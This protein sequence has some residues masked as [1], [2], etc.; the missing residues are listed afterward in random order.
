[1]SSTTSTDAP[2]SSSSS[3]GSGGGGQGSFGGVGSYPNGAAY[4]QTVVISLVALALLLM[5]SVVSFRLWACSARELQLMVRSPRVTAPLQVF[6]YYRRRRL[7]IYAASDWPFPSLVDGQG[8]APGRG[9]RRRKDDM[10]YG[11]KPVMHE[12]VIGDREEKWMEADGLEGYQVGVWLYSSGECSTSDLPLRSYH[13]LQ[14][15]A[16]TSTYFSNPG[17]HKLVEQKAEGADAEEP[18]VPPAPVFTSRSLVFPG[19]GARRAPGRPTQ[20][21]PSLLGRSSRAQADSPSANV[22]G[23]NDTAAVT[24]VTPS[25]PSRT[26]DTSIQVPLQLAFLVA[27]PRAPVVPG[28]VSRRTSVDEG[29]EIPEVMLGTTAV[30]VPVSAHRDDDGGKAD[31]TSLDLKEIFG[32]ADGPAATASA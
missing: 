4:F 1:M 20:G 3:G 28:Q 7:R 8:R 12:V 32:S 5:V 13:C 31:L 10:D 22:P 15:V 6:L 18:S 11:A 2:T 17:T 9:G 16:I 26:S 14:P 21:L 24:S 27:M 23:T 30:S 29:D 19:S 25:K